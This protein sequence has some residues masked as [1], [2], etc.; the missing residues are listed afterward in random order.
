[1]SS[2]NYIRGENRVY[3]F[4]L[5]YII[6]T[7]CFN[8]LFLSSRIQKTVKNYSPRIEDFCYILNFTIN[9]LVFLVTL[10]RFNI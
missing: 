1:M 10:K 6:L 5:T 4:Y 9:F 7:I 2:K 3:N 8:Y